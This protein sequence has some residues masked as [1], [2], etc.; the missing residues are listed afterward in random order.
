MGAM[1]RHMSWLIKQ[2]N[3]LQA[4]RQ[5]SKALQET[6]DLERRVWD[7]QQALREL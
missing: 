4:T 2:I 7:L 1:L 5:Y 6:N 3:E